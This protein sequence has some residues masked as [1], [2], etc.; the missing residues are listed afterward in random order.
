MSGTN[1]NVDFSGSLSELAR[2]LHAGFEK[3]DG[4]GHGETAQK[5]GA[6]SMKPPKIIIAT[7]GRATA[8]MIDGVVIGSG[9]ERLDFSTSDDRGERRPT[10]R[11]M[12]LDA[13]R[14]NFSTDKSWFMGWISGER[15]EIKE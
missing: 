4:E 9:I 14:V 10:I 8:A 7:D 2:V 12:N 11:I 6:V 13:R 1:I 3:S 15:T 5:D